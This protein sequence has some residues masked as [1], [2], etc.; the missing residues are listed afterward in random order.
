VTAWSP[1]MSEAERKKCNDEVTRIIKLARE[2]Q[3]DPDIVV[4]VA[5]SDA[6]TELPRNAKNA[7][8]KEM[9]AL[10]RQLP[11]YPWIESVRG[12]GA[13]GLAII[14]A[15]SGLKTADPNLPPENGNFPSAGHLRSRLYF[16]PYD[17]HAGSTWKRMTWRPRTLTKEEWTDHPFDGRRYARIFTIADSLLRAQ[18]KSKAKSGTRHGEP[19]G[20][21]GAVYVRRRE[22]DDAVHH[23]WTDG[24]AKSDALRIMMATVINDLWKQWNAETNLRLTPEHEMSPQQPAAGSKLCL[25]TNSA[26]A[27]PPVQ[28]RV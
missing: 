5:M 12:L 3:G 10:A 24:H 23:D 7:R 8:E 15:E 26:M 27:L 1:E 2:G 4:E 25:N 6:A 22:H 11:V 20:P 16:A 21:Y 13:K 28:D 17:G 18:I 19:L 9:E 14:V